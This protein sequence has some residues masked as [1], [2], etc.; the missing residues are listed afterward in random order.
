MAGGVELATAYVNLTVSAK[1]I[2]PQTSKAFSGVERQADLAGKSA[3]KRFGGGISSTLGG[4]AKNVGKMFAGIGVGLLGAGVVGAKF[5]LEIAASNEQAQISFETMLGSATKAKAFL[6]DLQ[7]FAAKTPFEFPELQTAASSLISAGIEANKV[8][9]IMT[10]LG[11]VTSGMGTGSEGV[12][13]ATIALQ[14]MSAAGRITGEDLN[15]LRDAGIPV[16]DLLSKATRKSKAEVVKLA[17]AGKLGTKELGQMMKALET[18]KGLE[19]FSGLMDKQSASLSGMIAT[20][21]DTLGQGLANA[22]QPLLPL[23]KDG[24]GGA[25]KFLAGFLPKVATGLKTVVEYGV[26]VANILCKG[27]FKSGPLSEDSGVVD[28]LFKIRDGL[29]KVKDVAVQAFGILFKGDF[30]GGPL[31]EDSEIVD[32]LFKVRQGLSN[33]IGAVRDFIVNFAQGEGVAGTFRSALEG[34]G[35]VILKVT[36]FIKDHIALFGGLV[37]VIGGGVLA[38]K[39]YTTAIAIWQGVTKAAAAVQV[40]FNAVLTANPIGIVIVAVAAL[41]AGLIYAYK[42]S[43]TFR[44]YVSTAFSVIKLGALTMARIAIT[45]IGGLVSVFL[46]MVGAVIS[47]AA[48][49]FGWV[50][51]LGP[52]LKTAAAK[53]ETFKTNTNASLDKIKNDIDL[54][55]RTE[56][57]NRALEELHR[58]FINKGW[59]VTATANVNMVYT[60]N[61]QVQPRANGG[62]VRA[63][64]AYIVG[65]RRPELF[66]PSSNGTIIP[67]V[68]KSSAGLGGLSAAQAYEAIYRGARDAIEGRNRGLSLSIQAVGR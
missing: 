37:A 67:R 7:A 50:P 33:V 68:P 10:T 4:V 17:Q 16:Y 47:G 61:G 44:S 22:V 41:A 63:G 9:P 19:R 55:I 51:G 32:T 34:A 46:G 23:I 54:K 5:G 26:Q 52:K 38:W 18:G 21:K 30:T 56:N 59:T 49:A 25:S 48:A 20:F 58:E 60:G 27:D 11:D 57:A 8:I 12:Q 42:T 36:G 66:V 3:G 6:G 62:P 2:A 24:L 1:D 39:A 40:L 64:S 45:A 53:F 13:R 14:Q 43:E 28:V 15:Q 65:E 29:G 35:T 31:S